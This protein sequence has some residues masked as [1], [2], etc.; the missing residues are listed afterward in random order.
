M[1]RDLKIAGSMLELIGDIPLVR[2]NRIGQETGAEILV[3]PEFLNPNG[4]RIPDRDR[5]VRQQDR[6]CQQASAASGSQKNW[7]PANG[8]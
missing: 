4:L 1:N 8:W 7:E 3:K 6:G 2:L 5:E